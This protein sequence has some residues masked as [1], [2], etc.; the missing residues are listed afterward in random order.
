MHHKLHSSILMQQIRYVFSRYVRHFDVPGTNSNWFDFWRAFPLMWLI[1]C[2][3]PQPPKSTVQ[4]AV[5]AKM[6]T[7]PNWILLMKWRVSNYIQFFNVL[8]PLILL[9]HAR[10][11]TQ[12]FASRIQFI[13]MIANFR[14]FNLCGK[15]CARATSSKCININS[16][17]L[18]QTIC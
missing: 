5:L 3:Q 11:H 6:P 12:L 16:F 17:N 13:C 9:T 10:T 14:P 8:L 7:H 18:L 1:Q 2:A 15:M 4:S